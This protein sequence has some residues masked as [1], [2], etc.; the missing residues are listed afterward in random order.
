LSRPVSEETSYRLFGDMVDGD[1]NRHLRAVDVDYISDFSTGNGTVCRFSICDHASTHIDA[2]IHTVEGAAS[3][4]SVD[5]SRLFGEAVVV[6]MYR[7]H[8]DAVYTAADFA[9]ARPAIEQG[10]I[11]LIYSGFQDAASGERMLQTHIDVEAA[12]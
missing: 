1:E 12:E 7:G 8:A 6:D 4:E 3:L 11:V 2:P 9:A 10:D 5:I